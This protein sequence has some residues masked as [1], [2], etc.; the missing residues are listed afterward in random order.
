VLEGT[1]AAAAGGGVMLTTAGGL[2]LPLRAGGAAVG[3][4][5]ALLIRPEK[6]MLAGGGDAL[7][8]G[9]VAEAIYLGE[10][11]RYVVRAAGDTLVVKQQNVAAGVSLKTGAR[12]GL[13]WDRE[14]E[15]RLG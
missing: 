7:V 13:R 11:T 10:A 1:V 12:V 9:E 4:R 6:I 8:E 5:L 2:R 14:S 3:E 15:R